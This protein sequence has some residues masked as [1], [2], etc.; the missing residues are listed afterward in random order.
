MEVNFSQ[1]LKH[2][3]ED[4]GLIQR[5]LAEK[6][7]VSRAT[8]TQYENN[9]RFPDQEM[10]KKIASF[11]NVS[12]DYLLGMTDIRK[13]KQNSNT[14]EKEDPNPLLKDFENLSPESQKELEKYLELLKLKENM[15]KSKDETSSAL[16]NEA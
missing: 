16:E 10:L 5:E 11:F 9:N 3:R 12:I 4:K 7:N 6:L 15:E 14:K 13:I 8:I 1:R 2:L